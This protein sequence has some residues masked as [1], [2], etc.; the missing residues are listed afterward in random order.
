MR[1]KWFDKLSSTAKRAYLRAHPKSKMRK[2]LNKIKRVSSPETRRFRTHVNRLR[3][4]EVRDPDYADE[5]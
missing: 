2:K 3:R 5:E 1:G 4:A